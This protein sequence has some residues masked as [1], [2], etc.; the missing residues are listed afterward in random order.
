MEMKK[1]DQGNDYDDN[2]DDV[3]HPQQQK[4]QS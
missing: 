4:Q 1:V 3:P 2:D